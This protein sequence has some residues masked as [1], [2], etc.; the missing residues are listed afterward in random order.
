MIHVYADDVGLLGMDAGTPKRGAYEQGFKKVSHSFLF[1]CFK[2]S[3]SYE[4]ICLLA[5]MGACGKQKLTHYPHL[6]FYRG[7]F[8]DAVL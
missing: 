4:I 1:L 2:S 8:S 7:V 3:Q 6:N 5:P